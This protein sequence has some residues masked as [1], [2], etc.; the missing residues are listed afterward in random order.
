[1]ILFIICDMCLK[2]FT[3]TTHTH[4]HTCRV[5]NKHKKW[6]ILKDSTNGWLKLDRVDGTETLLMV[7]KD[8]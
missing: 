5:Y 2:H 6:L 3:R 8:P 4:T 1:M 7:A